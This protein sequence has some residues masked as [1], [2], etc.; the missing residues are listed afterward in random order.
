MRA[1]TTG[2]YADPH[3]VHTWNKD[4]VRE[5]PVGHRYETLERDIGRALTFFKATGVDDNAFRTTD[6]YSSH[7]ALLL[8]YE[9]ALTWVDLRTNAPY[10]VSAHFVWTGERTRQ[11]DGA[12]VEL[13][14]HIKNPIGV[15]L[16]PDD[17]C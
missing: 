17:E 6:F 16:G 15:K 2:G 10:D 8:E 5:S 1:F 3:E 7:E 12:H 14:S 9:H 13:L 4:F 11:L